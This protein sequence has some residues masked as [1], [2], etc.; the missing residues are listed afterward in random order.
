ME[1][2]NPVKNS[3]LPKLPVTVENNRIKIGEKYYKVRIHLPARFNKDPIEVEKLNQEQQSEILTEV[4]KIYNKSIENIRKN[5]ISK[6]FKPTDFKY[7]ISYKKDSALKEIK[8]HNTFININPDIKTKK[9]FNE[10]NSNISITD[11]LEEKIITE[12]NIS[13]KKIIKS[14]DKDNTVFIQ[15]LSN[16]IN[17]S[18]K[19]VQDQVK[20]LKLDDGTT[21]YHNYFNQYLNQSDQLK[22]S[23]DND[24]KNFIKTKFN[25]I[26]ETLNKSFNSKED[27]SEIIEKFKN[28]K[29]EIKEKSSKTS[30]KD[31][32]LLELKNYLN[33]I[34]KIYQQQ[35]SSASLN[36]IN[37][38]EEIIDFDNEEII[39]FDDLNN[40]NNYTK[41]KDYKEI[42]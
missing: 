32:K 30:I 35:N 28:I 6:N 2:T 9:A 20:N 4:Q 25:N 21:T 16:K 24:T 29:Q 38:N 22:N 36:I 13:F 33:N 14:I 41:E 19:E 3:S 7:K 11:F 18:K 17:Y 27:L 1:K 15:G 23:D 31:V 37:N 40:S 39:D 5:V 34:I 8:I 26:E 42:N 10:K 12:M